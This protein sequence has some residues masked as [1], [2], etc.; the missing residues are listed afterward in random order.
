MK[1]HVGLTIDAELLKKI[2]EMRGLTKRS[3]FVEQLLKVAINLE[4][5]KR[6]AAERKLKELA[7]E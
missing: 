6:R 4:V 7:M 5:E 2:D 1:L 3:T